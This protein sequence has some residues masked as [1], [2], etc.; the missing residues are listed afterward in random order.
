MGLE[1]LYKADFSAPPALLMPRNGSQTLSDLPYDLRLEVGCAKCGRHG[2]YHV[3][4]LLERRGDL[5][6]TALHD[7]LTAACPA[8]GY[9]ASIYARCEARFLNLPRSPVS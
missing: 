2:R 7:E 8:Q 9:G 3:G 6:L 1:G 5:M 4:R